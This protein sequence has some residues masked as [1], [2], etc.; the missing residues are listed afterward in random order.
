MGLITGLL[1]Y[2]FRK[3][4]TSAASNL[5]N[6]W[7]S[8]GLTDA[9]REANAFTTSEREASQAWQE[10]MYN[11]Y[12]S[13][14]A[15]RQQMEQA[16]LNSALMYGSG[17]QTSDIGSA[18]AGSSVSPSSANN[19]LGAISQVL[20]LRNLVSN[21]SL[22]KAQAK[23]TSAEAE[24][25]SIDNEYLRKHHES[26]LEEQR[27]RITLNGAEVN[28][29]NGQVRLYDSEISLNTA[30]ELSL[31]YEN[32]LKSAQTAEKNMLVSV[33]PS[34]YA[35]LVLENNA[36][37]AK[38]SQEV[39]NLKIMEKKGLL[40]Y[41]Q[42]VAY[43]VYTGGN[44]KE[45]EYFLNKTQLLLN[46]AGIDIQKFNAELHKIS[47]QADV[48]FKQADIQVRNDQLEI[49]A[50]DAQTRRM[51]TYTIPLSILSK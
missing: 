2:A 22:I 7:T 25:Q 14:L 29:K 38:F 42:E 9:D 33:L 6:R 49:N 48:D 8:S 30:K 3:K 51:Q 35:S 1:G 28:V 50:F 31:G 41:K 36:S 37:A 26:D 46:A 40:E 15:I 13:P 12:E 24:R 17:V 5:W 10:Q 39:K 20:E 16:G 47:V 27:T 32:A 11:K 23:K 43:D 21:N 18:S 44:P 19:P 34:Y 45:R 4:L